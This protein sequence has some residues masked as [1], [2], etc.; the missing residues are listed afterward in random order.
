MIFGAKKAKAKTP[1]GARICAIGDIHGCA[2]KLDAL[3][4]RIDADDAKS[5]ARA[6]LVFLGDYVDRGQDSRG[7]VDRLIAL[8]RER[9]DA[10]FLKGNHEDVFLAFLADPAA[11]EDWLGWGGVET[12]ESYGV[13]ARSEFDAAE[14]AASARARV[15]AAH[16]EFLRRLELYKVIG[17]YLFVHA[18]VRPGRPLEQ[19]EESDLLWIRGEFHRA[20]PA[21]R[22]AQVVVHGHQPLRKPLD[23]GWRIDVD[24]GA[25]FGGELT[26]VLLEGESRRFITA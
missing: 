5:G 6:R 7:V 12:L 19:Q 17:D 18:G 8:A 14:I 11:N 26:G 21:E 13:A 2:D 15:P 3:I 23:A 20:A 9:G 22:P 25:C 4:A 16:L 10:V 24:T 1:D